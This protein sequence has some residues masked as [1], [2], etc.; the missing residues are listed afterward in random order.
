MKKQD[1]QSLQEKSLDD[2]KKL[3]SQKK[4]EILKVQAEA[5]V[6][7]HKNVKIVWNLRRDLAQINTILRQKEI[8]ESTVKEE[9]GE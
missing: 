5:S 2:L 1:I 8:L 7:K 3:V 6:G 9:K 4:Q